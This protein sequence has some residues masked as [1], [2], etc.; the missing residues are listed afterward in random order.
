MNVCYINRRIS[1][2]ASDSS[3]DSHAQ[4]FPHI[5]L[6]GHSSLSQLGSF[7]T[8][9]SLQKGRHTLTPGKVWHICRATRD[10]LRLL[11]L[12]LL[13]LLFSPVPV[14][15]LPLIIRDIKRLEA[16]RWRFQI[17]HGMTF[18]FGYVGGRLAVNGLIDGQVVL[19]F[20]QVIVDLL[21][22]F[23]LFAVFRD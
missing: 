18:V 8:K 1:F 17:L 15:F 19:A 13:R 7:K 21:L 23:A 22:L 12:S 6:D 2:V 20:R 14:L 11:R 3:T 10:D 9:C 5:F 4:T 16:R